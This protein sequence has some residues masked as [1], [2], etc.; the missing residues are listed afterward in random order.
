MQNR[1]M[2]SLWMN[3]LALGALMAA[4]VYLKGAGIV[5]VIVWLVLVNVWLFMLMA[6]DKR[7]SGREGARTPEVTLLLLG[8]A[9]ASPVLIFGRKYLKHKTKKDS[10]VASVWAVAGIQAAALV[11]WLLR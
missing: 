7:A 1:V 11:W 8:L 5:T 10:F 6:K 3:V 9:G 4:V 2:A